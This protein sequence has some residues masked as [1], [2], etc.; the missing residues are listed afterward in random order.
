MQLRRC[1]R[2]REPA[3]TAPVPPTPPVVVVLLRYVRS[4]NNLHTN[5]FFSSQNVPSCVPS[6]MYWTPLCVIAHTQRAITLQNEQ[7]NLPQ[8]LPCL[9]LSRCRRKAADGTLF[10]SV[11]SL[12]SPGLIKESKKVYNTL[13]MAAIN[14]DRSTSPTAKSLQRIGVRTLVPLI[15]NFF[16]SSLGYNLSSLCAGYFK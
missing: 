14:V 7:S 15:F 5:R 1:Y 8:G 9:G 4:I 16:Q 13:E 12:P 11:F 6:R 3:D 10:L 2:P